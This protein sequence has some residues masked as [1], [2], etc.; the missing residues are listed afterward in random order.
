MALLRISVRSILANKGRFVLTTFA[1]VMGVGFVVASLVVTDSLRASVDGLF[2]EVTSGID[3][4]VRAESNLDGP[5]PVRDQIPAHL[6]QELVAVDGVEVAQQSVE[7]YAQLL[8]SGGE[9]VGSTGSP[10]IGVSWGSDESI[11]GAALVDGR[12]PEGPSEVAIDRGTASDY[13]LGVGDRT[14]VLLADGTD[15][16]VQVVGIF[17]F[18]S[19]NNVLGARITAFDLATA[20]DL[21]GTEG[22]VDSID[23]VVSPDTSADEII[24]RI[25]P[26][27]PEGVEVVTAREVADESGA[28]VAGYLDAFRNVL[29]GFAGVALLVSA[30]FIHNTLSISVGQ[31]TRQL[32][33]LQACGATPGQVVR[34]V[35]GEALVIGLV[36]AVVGSG[37][38]LLLAT[39]LKAGFSAAGL[40]L[41]SQGSVIA[42]RT[43]VVALVVGLV[44]TVAAAAIP[45]R[46]AATITPVEG[47]RDGIVT[48]RLSTA[49]RGWSGLVLVVLGA[50][51]I[52]AGVWLAGSTRA[53]VALLVLG[54]LGIF[55][56]IAQ[57]SPVAVIP[58]AGALGRP[59]MSL[60]GVA[61]RLGHANVVR[62]ADRTARAASALTI[63]LA[64]V[65]TVLVA[66]ASMKDNLITSIEG[67]IAADYVLS[68]ESY[69]G[70]SPTVTEAVGDL[71]EID[72]VSGVRMD[73]F[74][75]DGDVRQLVAADSEVAATLLDLDVREG[76]IED[77]DDRSIFLHSD[78]ASSRNLAV[79][80]TVEVEFAAGGPQDLTVAGIYDDATLV[81][82]YLVDLDLL[83][84]Y[85][86]RN[87]LDIFAFAHVAPGVVP[88]DARAALE[89]LLDDHPTVVLEDR[90]AWRDTQVAEFD[91]VLVAVN[92]L[93][94]LA[95]FI[96]LLG[97]GNTLA[98]SVLE[99]TREIG[100][101][102]AVGMLPIQV[103]RMVLVESVLVTVFGAVFGVIVGVVFGLVLTAALPESLVDAA[104]VPYDTMLLTVV[105]AAACGVLA[106]L[107]P[108][109]RAARLDVLDAIHSP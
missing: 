73:S 2:D 105:A 11:G 40:N 46:R 53:T 103:R 99:R 81:G 3:V 107:L 17:T 24:D 82:N 38:G 80:D 33:L 108:A 92:G 19:A 9:A 49:Q 13:E 55:I 93:L 51:G 109:R 48:F 45:A 25:R 52:V 1:V 84:R 71:D 64:M 96:A 30:F 85:N 97:I 76:D 20:V 37:F 66:G 79:G 106:G 58:A 86:P 42:P 100:L 57:L 35:V 67:S 54:A 26:V 88:A 41:P 29:L 60:V 22:R 43:L 50:I 83:R 56:G 87:D 98:L 62:N 95:L 28:A 21:F 8:D 72:A 94:L 23:V 7:G 63:G 104:V 61:G 12:A 34:S 15:P 14:T 78:P 75:F 18:G 47:M 74:L 102:R 91:T 4:V 90:A 89:A 59:L 44:V 5:V 101:L 65:T 77:L 36:A 70:F 10:F 39:L 27:L 32:A 31:R 69:I 68:T 16:E 6:E